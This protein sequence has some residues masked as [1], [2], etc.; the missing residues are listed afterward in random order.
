[1]ANTAS[2]G[3]VSRKPQSKGQNHAVDVHKA[4]RGSGNRLLVSSA[5]ERQRKKGNKYDASA[6]E[7]YNG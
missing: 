4:W 1:M 2:K 7:A 6:W 3:A 5:L